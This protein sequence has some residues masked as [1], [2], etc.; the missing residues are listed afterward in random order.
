MGRD[1][2]P[3][4]DTKPISHVVGFTVGE[5]L[6]TVSSINCIYRFHAFTD[7]SFFLV[8][9]GDIAKCLDETGQAFS[10]CLLRELEGFLSLVLDFEQA[11]A[12]HFCHIVVIAGIVIALFG[13]DRYRDYR[14]TA[15]NERASH[16]TSEAFIDSETGRRIPEYRGGR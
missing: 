16:P 5:D 10:G 1:V 4:K 2:F 6:R 9:L 15:D 14:K 3:L 11:F 13:W 8:S 12:E 7:R